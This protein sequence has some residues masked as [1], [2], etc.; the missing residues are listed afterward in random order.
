[1]LLRVTCL[2]N[3]PLLWGGGDGRWGPEIV[4]R[5]AGG[6]GEEDTYLSTPETALM[7][8]IYR[9]SRTF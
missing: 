9:E 1:M 5:D 8:L 3:I 7:A 2:L 4:G 6:G